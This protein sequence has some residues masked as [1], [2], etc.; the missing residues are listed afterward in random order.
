MDITPFIPATM[1]P[2]NLESLS[3]ETNL[4]GLKWKI[5]E[6][7]FLELSDRSALHPLPVTACRPSTGRLSKLLFA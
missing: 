3:P 6:K 4:A 7:A 1:L 2:Q 5:A